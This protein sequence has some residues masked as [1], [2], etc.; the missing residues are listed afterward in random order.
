[1][2][3]VVTNLIIKNEDTLTIQM[4]EVLNKGLIQNQLIGQLI[5][6]NNNHLMNQI[7]WFISVIIHH[8]KYNQF[9]DL[10]ENGRLFDILSSFANE[11]TKNTPKMVREYLNN[12][13]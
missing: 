4:I 12:C 3:L 10:L 1:M 8:A 2:I 9:E 6:L 7:Q 13:D 11:L 5:N